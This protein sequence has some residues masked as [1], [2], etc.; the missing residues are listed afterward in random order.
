[1]AREHITQGSVSQAWARLRKL[2][3]VEDVHLHDMRKVIASWLGDRGERSDV[4]D[5]ILHHQ[6]GHHT[7]QRG[8][9]TESHYNFSVMAGPLRDAWQRWADHVASSGWQCHGTLRLICDNT[10]RLLQWGTKSH[11]AKED[12]RQFRLLRRY[13]WSLAT[14][15]FGLCVQG[16][17]QWEAYQSRIGL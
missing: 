14:R 6:V 13:T 5:R 9:V 8:C 11:H 7:N 2:A 1:M 16:V 10:R 4:L 17:N 15:L 3:G 12:S